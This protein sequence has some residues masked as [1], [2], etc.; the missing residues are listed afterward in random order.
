MSPFKDLRLTYEAINQENTFRAGDTIIGT[1]SFNL[2]EDTK[3]TSVFVK[4]KGHTHVHFSKGSGD[5]KK[6]YTE[7]R[8]HFKVK[9]HLVAENDQGTVLPKGIHNFNFSLQIPEWDLPGSFKGTSGKIVYTVEAKITRSWRLSSTVEKELMFVSDSYTGQVMC[10]Q[11]GSVS[12]GKVHMFATVNRKICSP[13]DVLSV[14]AKISNASSKSMKPKFSLQRKTVFT[15]RNKTKIDDK[16]ILKI[17]GDTVSPNSEVTASC[18]VQIPHD[19]IYTLHNCEIISVEYY[20]KVYLDISFAFDPE[21]ELPLVVVPASWIAL[22][23]S[24]DMG[25]SLPGAAGAPSYSDF[26]PQALPVGLNPVPMDSGPPHYPAPDPAQY[27]TAASAPHDQ[28]PQSP[29]FSGFSTDQHPA[30]TAP[31]AF[32]MEEDPPSYESIFLPSSDPLGRSGSNQKS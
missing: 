28:W 29:M 27:T 14:V 30:P 26:P 2:R 9:E 4:A 21:V 16:T 10:P 24:E 22:Q 25:P 8:R 32:E 17:K 15:A 18:E 7:D 13:G 12:E 31:P 3:V 20:L 5:N 19:A 23:L 6:S 11:S 1:V